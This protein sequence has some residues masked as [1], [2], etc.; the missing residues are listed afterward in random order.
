M[1]SEAGVTGGPADQ[2]GLVFQGLLRRYRAA[3]TCEELGLS[4]RP[5]R[6]RRA[7]APSGLRQG[8]VDV[9]LGLGYGVYQRVESGASR[10]SPQLFDSIT[11]L[12]RFSQHDVRVAQ[13][14]LFGTEPP[15][16]LGPVSA[17]WQ[18]V[19]DGQRGMAFVLA[20]NGD[21][22]AGNSASAVMFPSRRRPENWW[23]WSLLDPSREATLTQWHTAWAPRLLA[24]FMLASVR[25]PHDPVLYSIR[26]AIQ[27]DPAV[28]SILAA[29]QGI[30][31]QTL[32]LHHPDRGPG[33]G[34]PLIAAGT[35]ATLVT[36][37]FDSVTT[38]LSGTS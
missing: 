28:R 23:R 5:S 29:D 19:V 11:D 4:P 36:V 9:A 31:G 30:D 37:T 35:A 2:R 21:L 25:H 7:P 24:D 1:A 13:L 8:D 14:D 3:R 26:S 32:P 12:L 38:S 27:R 20:A 18:D 10:P 17:R 34:H 6:G 22:I 16:P 15:P 33:H